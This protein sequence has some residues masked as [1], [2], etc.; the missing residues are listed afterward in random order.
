[1]EA[2]FIGLKDAKIHL[3]KLNGVKIAVPVGKMAIEDLEYVEKVTGVSLDE[4]KPLSD[5]R[6]RSQK[7]GSSKEQGKPSSTISEPGSGASVVAQQSKRPD[8]DWFD[9][10][11]KCGV[12]PSQCERYSFNFIRDSM[13]DTVLPDITPTVLNTLG[14]KQGDIL[15]VMKF[16][17]NKYGRSGAK[18]K[19]RNVSFGGEEVM[20]NEG[21]EEGTSAS[22]SSGLFSG[23]GGTLKN[24]TRKGRPAPPVQTNDTIDPKAFQRGSVD[25][26]KKEGEILTSTRSTTSQ[27]TVTKKSAG[28]DDDAWDVKPLEQPQPAPATLPSPPSNPA[29]TATQA[30]LTGSMADLSLLSQP[31]QPVI[32]HSTGVPPATQNQQ[33]SR[34]VQQPVQQQQ[35][36]GP[37]LQQPQS[38]Q[39]LQQPPPPQS[40]V[41]GYLQQHQTGASPS[42]F[43]SLGTQVNGA[44]SFI[45]PTSPLQN[46]GPQPVGI[47]QQQSYSNQPQGFN[48]QP[49]TASQPGFQLNTAPRQRPQAPQFNQQGSLMPPPPPRP[50][51]APQNVSPQN[52]FGAPPLQP[53]LTGIPAQASVQN[54]VS[55]STAQSL[56]ELSRL[57]MQQQFVQQPHQFQQQPNG[58]SQPNQAFNQYGTGFNQ[59]PNI[60]GQQ[61]PQLPQASGAQM[62]SQYINGQP[63]GG[64]YPD[65]R[66]PPTGSFPPLTASINGFA[67][68]AYSPTVPQ[69]TGSINSILPPALQP[70]Q[71]GINGFNAPH[72]NQSQPPT[73]PPIPPLPQQHIP[74]TL[75]P[76]KTGPAPPVQFGVAPK[77]K[78]LLPQVTGRRANLS[79]ASKF[80]PF[81]LSRYM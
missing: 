32:A 47:S 55:S 61:T 65:L 48:P 25:E 10:F 14:L 66:S 68:S 80:S 79:Q 64:L 23:P 49:L 53:Q 33:T 39:Q 9:F 27:P 4:D 71:T 43:A 76:Q 11:L 13:D 28:F 3:H 74:A 70:Q 54:Q 15:R 60:Y 46:V 77:A 5:I 38:Q 75:Q 26:S 59:Q 45:P 7:E 81:G 67:S 16:L 8:F 72:F 6:R 63:T 42:F 56:D 40:A 18:S 29:S 30:T 69:H 19:L 37:Q 1:V 36:R 31:L 52:N 34:P 2:E 21:E 51:S 35:S 20:G 50:L 17:D 62:P 22:P 24:N 41:L 57:R 12:N 78:T 73:M 44:Q 58:F